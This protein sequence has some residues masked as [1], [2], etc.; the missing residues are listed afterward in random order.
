MK[1]KWELNGTFFKGDE[2]ETRTSLIS[3]DNNGLILVDAVTI[4][5]CCPTLCTDT[6]IKSNVPSQADRNEY[7]AKLRPKNSRQ[8]H[9]V[10]A[11]NGNVFAKAIWHIDYF[12]I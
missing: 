8:T 4:A 6:E 1:R 7:E 3:Q 12:H 10:L 5:F 11:N 9:Q 2:D